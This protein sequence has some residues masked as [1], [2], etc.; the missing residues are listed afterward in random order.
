[1]RHLGID[2]G[3]RRIG[4]ALSDEGGRFSTPLEVLQVSAPENALD[5]ILALIATEAVEVLVIGL[6]LN[7][8]GSEGASAA[9]VRQW[10]LV[11]GGRAQK[12]IVFVDE[13]LSSYEAEQTLNTRR[14]AGERLTH[15]GKKRRLDAVAAA[16]LLQAYLDGLLEA[17][18][19]R[20]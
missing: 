13:R 15:A 2:F 17:L 6:P 11:L 4:L 3:T 19:E 5:R 14:R 10:A 12:P 1:M 8:D 18:P 16:Q 7:M 9:A 20:K